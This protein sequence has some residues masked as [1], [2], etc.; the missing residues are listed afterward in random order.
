MNLINKILKESEEDELE[1]EDLFKPRKVENRK[2][3]MIKQLK[4]LMSNFDMD[5][6]SNVWTII[7]E[8]STRNGSIIIRTYFV[9]GNDKRAAKI[10]LEDYIA[11]HKWHQQNISDIKPFKETDTEILYDYFE[12]IKNDNTTSK[13]FYTG[14]EHIF[15]A[16][17]Q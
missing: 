7:T 13:L 4:E 12:S 15:F 14:R 1:S 5:R 16:D 8:E 6:F 9:R 3:E 11:K 10:L 17:I 2:L